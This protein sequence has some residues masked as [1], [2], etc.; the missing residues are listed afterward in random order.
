MPKGIKCP[1]C[2]KFNSTYEKGAYHC[3]N[4]QCG[5]VW[6]TAF[7][8]PSAGT[9]RKGYTCESCGKQTVHPIADVA[10][11]RIWRCSTCATTIV[12]PI[13]AAE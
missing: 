13:P 6:W 8:K 4:K 7:D 1:E 12:K 2:G 9:K 5:A 3:G 11:A 10:Q